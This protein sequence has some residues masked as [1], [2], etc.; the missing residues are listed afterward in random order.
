MQ[1]MHYI[2]F[3]HENRKTL[4]QYVSIQERLSGLLSSRRKDQVR[5]G[6]DDVHDD[7]DLREFGGLTSSD[8]D[9]Q[10]NVLK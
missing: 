4:R 2:S 10:R 8:D 9:R 1:T 6:D 7:D 3:H 5:R